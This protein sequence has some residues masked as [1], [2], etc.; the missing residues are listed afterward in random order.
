MA[1][2]TGG[3][4]YLYEVIQEWGEMPNKWTYDIAG[5]A[6]D[7]RGQIYM[8]NRGDTPVV[9]LDERGHFLYGWGD[10]KMFPRAHG[11]TIGPDDSVWLTDVYDHTVRKCTTQGEVLL[12]IGVSGKPAPAMSGEPFNQC[13][14]VALDPRTGDIFVS[15]GYLNPKVHKYTPD[16]RLMFSWGQP[17]TGPENSIYRITSP[18]IVTDTSTLPIA[19]TI[20]CK[21]SPRTANSSIS[22]PG[23]RC[24][25]GCASIPAARSN[26]ATSANSVR[27]GGP[28]A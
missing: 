7:S 5:V 28:W 26:F 4:N 19:T 17:A 24:R 3:G 27:C 1:L 12:T 13:T 2:L 23:W 21:S 18:R 8:F 22:G 14:H 15:D 16:G 11:I 10:K 20:A 9:I 25:A 6:V